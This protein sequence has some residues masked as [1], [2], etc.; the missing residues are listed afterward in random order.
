[1]RHFHFWCGHPIAGLKGQLDF[2]GM[3]FERPNRGSGFCGGHPSHYVVLF[4]HDRVSIDG[5]APTDH[6][7][8][9]LAP[10]QRCAV[11]AEGRWR[12]S[13]LQC[14][15]SLVEEWLRDLPVPLATP[16]AMSDQQLVQAHLLGLFR[17]LHDHAEPRAE[18]V[19]HWTQGVFL[20]MAM[21]HRAETAPR[22]VIPRRFSVVRQYIREHYRSA[23]RLDDLAAM[24]DCSG[25]WLCRQFR[26][27]F[28]IA[29][30]Q[31]QTSL[32]LA[33]IALAI[34]D[35]DTPIQSLAAA[36]GYGDPFTFSKLFK[37]HYGMG[38]QAY[39]RRARGGSGP[40]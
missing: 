22:V 12:H 17:E 8:V 40:H 2:V 28:G 20:E 1:M 32:R 29:P 37:R 18:L 23:L 33:D 16:L 13:W 36:A 4:F 6:Q 38:P 3:G 14:R 5:A 39:R 24:A 27:Y 35:T 9:V 15:G 7:A 26:R 25:P 11:T 19:S 21:A 30:M 10:G 34:S 31:L